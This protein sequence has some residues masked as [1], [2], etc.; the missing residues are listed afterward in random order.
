[1][2]R[3][4][5]VLF[6]LTALTI[7]HFVENLWLVPWSPMMVITGIL[8]IL[9][10]L[11]YRR[12]EEL[13]LKRPEK[14]KDFL[15]YTAL[16]IAVSLAMSMA[17][18]TVYPIVIENLGLKGNIQY[19]YW[20]AVN[21]WIEHIMQKFGGELGFAWL[22][23]FMLVWT[24]IGEELLYRGYAFN[25]LR[26]KRSFLTASTIST[27]YFAARHFAHLTPSLPTLPIASGLLYALVTIPSTYIVCYVLQ[28]TGSLYSTMLPHFLVNLIP[29]VLYSAQALPK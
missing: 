28:K 11:K 23:L 17:V 8:A 12:R 3:E 5:E 25:S 26:E 10:P 19:D 16:N 6:V 27:L 29:S 14:R 7:L 18:Q 15:K 21:S 22:G 20:A 4:K 24:P 9:V 1:M 2:D 13:G